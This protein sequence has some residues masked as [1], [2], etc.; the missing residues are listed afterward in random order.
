M[1]PVATLQAQLSRLTGLC[2]RPFGQIRELTKREQF[3]F[4]SSGDTWFTRWF[5]AAPLGTRRSAG[6]SQQVLN[7]S[8]RVP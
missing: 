5:I 3:E 8:V 1:E 4:V 7:R 2:Y 6:Q